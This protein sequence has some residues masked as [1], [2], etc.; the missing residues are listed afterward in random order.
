[1]EPSSALK[2]WADAA[3]ARVMRVFFCPATGCI[4]DCEPRGVTPAADFPG[5]LLRPELGYGHGLEDCA[6]LGGVALSGLV[7]RHAVEPSPQVRADAAAVARGLA[8]L[9]SA[10][11]YAG[12]VARG[13]CVEDGRSICRVSSRDQVTHWAHGL[14]R[15][16]LGGMASG[17][18]AAR[19]RRLFC[20]V[21]ARMKRNVTAENDWNFLQADG[22]PDPYGVC[23]MRHVL[24]HEA[25]RLAMVYGLAWKVTGDDGWRR[26]YEALRDEAIDGSRFPGGT[27]MDVLEA[28]MPDYSL[29]QMNTSLEALLMVEADGPRRGKIAAAMADCARLARGRAFKRTGADTRYLCGCAEVHLAQMMAPR[30]VFDWDAGQRALLAG[31]ILH[32]PASQSGALRAVHLFA[33]YWRA[34]QYGRFEETSLPEAGL[35]KS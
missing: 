20:E 28:R 6:I 35:R 22:L 10:H 30:D 29:H 7:D 3:W 25:A 31:A 16:L 18:E 17:D 21:A 26:E 5:G 23:K 9:V 15:Y 11:P 2:D 27:E 1:M 4:Y 19:A 32:T 8:N 24:P 33:A 34:R 12:F 14:G 13:L